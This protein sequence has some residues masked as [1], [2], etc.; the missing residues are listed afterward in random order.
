MKLDVWFPTV[1]GTAVCPFIDT[2][3]GKYKKIIKKYP[4]IN[5]GFINYP[6]HQDKRFK[7]L[8][9]W[10]HAE[11]NLFGKKHKFAYSYEAKESWVWDYQIG[12]YQG[13]H[14]HPGHTLSATF[15]LE[16]YVKDVPLLFINPIH[17]MK[18]PLGVQAHTSFKQDIYNP[19]TFTSCHYAPQ[20]GLLLIWR[21]YLEHSV[22][23]KHRPEKRIVFVYNFDPI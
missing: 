12:A 22:D 13:S 18:N 19:F 6:I 2:I 14:T 9:D 20:S 15:F 8:N 7:K 11:V 10:I 23:V 16:G 17:D 1:I 4:S 5:K 3:Q 21:S